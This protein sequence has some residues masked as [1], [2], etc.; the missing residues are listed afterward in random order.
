MRNGA[1]GRADAEDYASHAGAGLGLYRGKLQ[2][3][4]DKRHVLYR[5]ICIASFTR[6]M[7]CCAALP[8]AVASA[9]DLTLSRNFGKRTQVNGFNP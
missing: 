4:K 3:F 9:R 5:R 6:I 8:L 1:R 7:S 2:P